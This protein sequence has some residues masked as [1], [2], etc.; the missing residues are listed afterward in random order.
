[1][2]VFGVKK[3]K[4]PPPPQKQPPKESSDP[5]VLS[6]S[7][8]DEDDPLEN[9]YLGMFLSSLN[10]YEELHNIEHSGLRPNQQKVETTKALN[11]MIED[12]SVKPTDTTSIYQSRFDKGLDFGAETNLQGIYG[13]DYVLHGHY[14]DSGSVKP[15]SLGLKKRS[16]PYGPRLNADSQVDDRLAL[17]KDSLSDQWHKTNAFSQAKIRQAKRNRNRNRKGNRNRGRNRNRRRH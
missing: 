12:E 16:D 6:G 17:E 13:D 15:G 8:K 11:E 2:G 14:D 3:Q 10:N 1:M 5:K 9:G 4:T 7:G